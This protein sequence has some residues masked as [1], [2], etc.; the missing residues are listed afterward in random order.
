[1]P[2]EPP[3]DADL[4]PTSSARSEAIAGAEEAFHE[5]VFD[6]DVLLH[7]VAERISRGTGDYC[8]VG[9]VSPDGRRFQPLVAYHSDPRLVEDSR[10]FLGVSMDIDAAGPWARVLKERQTVITAIDPDHLPPDMAPHQVRHIQRWRIREAALIPLIAS[11]TVVGGL[12]LNRLEG[13]P[14]LY[15]G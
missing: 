2:P 10:P 14:A 13:W 4:G 11:D 1:M 9:L 5:A 15:A 7:I 3:A 12:N 6:L 8:S